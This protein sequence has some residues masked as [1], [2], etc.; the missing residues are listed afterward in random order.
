MHGGHRADRDDAAAFGHELRRFA[1]RGIDA[2]DVDRE[3]AR[4]IFGFHFADRPGDE[5]AGVVHQDVEVTEVLGHLV[6]SAPTSSG[7]AWS[8]WNATARTPLS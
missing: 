6:T 5:H 1:H 4:H 7:L 2:A 3:L 8:A